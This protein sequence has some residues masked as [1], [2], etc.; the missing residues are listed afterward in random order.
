MSERSVI[1]FATNKIS[2]VKFALNC[3]QS[4][5]LHNDIPVFIVTNLKFE[6]PSKIRHRVTL[7]EA[8]EE[9]AGLG[10][11]IKVYIDHYLQ[12]EQTLFIDSD[13]LCYGNLDAI[14]D[15]CKGKSVSVIGTVVQSALWCGKQQ[16]AAIAQN[17]ALTHLIR[18]NGGLYFLKKNTQAAEVF[19]YARGI[20]PRYDYLG[21][22]RLKNGWLNEEGPISIAMMV[23]GQTPIVDDGRYMTD[24]S[25]DSYPYRLNVLTGQIRLRNPAPGNPKHRPWY[26]QAYS[27]IVLHFGGNNL[28]SVI[29]RSQ[30][31]LLRFFGV[32]IPKS[33]ASTLVNAFI[34][35]PYKTIK[36]LTKR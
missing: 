5:L 9:H 19:D 18:F 12:T 30:V 15:A 26:P 34:H 27:P 14:F 1:T 3:A 10:I 11:G 22:N 24:L 28:K 29:Y 2:Y 6:I 17:F 36:W 16:A 13:C 25:T 8:R 23:N 21:F 4:V 31:L 33:I 7:I 32:A 35:N 20:I